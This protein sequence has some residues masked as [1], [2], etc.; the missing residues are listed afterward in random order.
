MA[1]LPD[2]ETL[3]ALL[4]YEPDTGKLFWKERPLEMFKSER[5]W[6]MW[7]TRFAGMEAFASIGRQGYFQGGLYNKTRYAHRV[8]W[9]LRHGVEPDQ[10]DHLDG[11][12]TNNRLHNL[13]EVSAAENR[14]NQRRPERNVSGVIGVGWSDQRKKWRAQIQVDGKCKHLGLFEDLEAAAIARKEAE[15]QYGFHPNH[16]RLA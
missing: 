12:R 11:D 7:N 10:I 4:R 16:G 1:E 14:K 8:I 13:R 6:K 3:Q 15:I 9:K 2:Q 5:S